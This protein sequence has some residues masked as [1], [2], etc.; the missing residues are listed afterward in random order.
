MRKFGSLGSRRFGGPGRGG[1]P[2]QPPAVDPLASPP[3]L[4][5]AAQS[6]FTDTAHIDFR[7][8]WEVDGSGL[9]SCTGGNAGQAA[10]LSLD[11]A[12]T[13]GRAHFIL[14]DH[15]PTAGSL[16][17]RFASPG[18]TNSRQLSA[19]Y[20]DCEF[21]PAGD[22]EYAA[23]RL[24][25]Q[26]T[27]DYAGTVDNVRAYDLSTVD[28]NL[29]ACDVI[30]VGGDSNSANAT[31]ER[32]GDEIDMSARETPF[33]PRIWYMPCLRLSGTFPTTDSV[34]HIPQPCIEPVAAVEARRMSPVHAVAGELVGWSAARG[35]P[36]LVMA[37]GD[38][39]SGLMGTEDWRSSST[40]E[41]EG[42]R[43]WNELLAMK[44]A[45]EALGPNHEIVGA[46]W[47]MGANDRFSAPSVDAYDNA[48]LAP[49]QTFFAEVRALIGDV[50]QVLWNIGDHVVRH[51]QSIETPGLGEYMQD[52]LARFDKDSG[53]PNAI[54]YVTVVHPQ[55]GNQYTTDDDP[56]YNAHGMQ[57][58]G[59][60]AG[61]ALLSLLA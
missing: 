11:A 13:P 39:G 58:N 54:P 15:R 9:L 37:L 10:R 29:V 23:T 8:N 42:A 14:A 25:L 46:V 36:L 24:D 22:V 1:A 6:A 35:R 41:P 30:I 5:T 51:S 4:F 44:A 55:D 61:Q 43:M 38:P 49:Y 47:S 48:H 18:I 57:Q 32:F 3:N 50:P 53:H 60:D 27:T 7:S 40:V 52:W 56:H 2:V 26:P 17:M 16:R 21:V 20:M 19:L 31:S 28:P 33:D 12:L 34:R 59:R 45:V